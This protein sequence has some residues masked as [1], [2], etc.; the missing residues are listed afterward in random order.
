MPV[1]QNMLFVSKMD[2][3]KL[4]DLLGSVNTGELIKILEKEIE[5]KEISTNGTTI[6]YYDIRDYLM[7]YHPDY[8]L[9]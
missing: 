9:N 5:Q 2:L 7:K 8:R 4:L 3:K 1:Y 6:Y